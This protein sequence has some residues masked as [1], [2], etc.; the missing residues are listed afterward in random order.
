[1]QH[2]GVGVYQVDFGFYIYDRF[3]SGVA[4]KNGIGAGIGVFNHSLTVNQVT[5]VTALGGDLF[6][7]FFDLIVY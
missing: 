4:K 7:L 5:V 1:M 3:F 6:D 2:A